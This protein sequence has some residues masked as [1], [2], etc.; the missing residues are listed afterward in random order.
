MV[1]KC[2]YCKHELE[3]SECRYCGWHLCPN[4]GSGME[5]GKESEGKY[6]WRCSHC[7]YR[8]KSIT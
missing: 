6:Y 1:G 4:C 3:N 2:P 5:W 7:G 8:G